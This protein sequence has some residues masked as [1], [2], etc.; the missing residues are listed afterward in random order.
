MAAVFQEEKPCTI[1]EKRE[2]LL[3]HHVALW[4]VI[5]S[6]EIKGSSDA[7]ITNVVANDLTPILEKAQIRRILVNG[8]TA[9]KYYQKYLEPVTH[10]KA[11][12]MP[13]TSPANAAWKLEQ[14]V[15]EWGKEL[16]ESD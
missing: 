6:C 16:K 8:K 13:S 12:C 11:V 7:S 1:P 15:Q 3:R 2:F 4:D 5:H 10:R 9:E 14:L